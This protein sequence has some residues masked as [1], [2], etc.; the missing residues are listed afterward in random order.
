MVVSIFAL[1]LIMQEILII[2]K[3]ILDELVNL[4]NKL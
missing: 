2:L 4:K 1:F 3:L